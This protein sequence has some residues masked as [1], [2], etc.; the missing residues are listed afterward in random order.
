MKIEAIKKNKSKILIVILLTIFSLNIESYAQVSNQK[1]I[2]EISQEI[3]SLKSQVSK[4]K[5]AS[6]NVK[7]STQDNRKELENI[8]GSM[9]NID[10]K[11]D[12]IS[13]NQAHKDDLTTKMISHLSNIEKDINRLVKIKVEENKLEN[14]NQIVANSADEVNANVE[15]AASPFAFGMGASVVS[16]YVWRGNDFGESPS[17]QPYMS[18]SYAGLELG[19]WSS[20]PF[21]TESSDFNEFDLYLAYSVETGI[22]NFGATLTDYHYPNAGLSFT[23]WEGDG[24]GAHTIEFAMTYSN[25]NL[26]IS[27]MAAYNVHNDPDNSLYLELGYSIDV[28][29]VPV[30]IFVGGAQGTSAWYGIS[31]EKF[32][33]IN[34][35]LTLSKEIKLWDS[36][37]LPV[38]ASYIINPYIGKGF[39][40]FGISI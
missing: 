3:K 31:T 28:N 23:N 12:E 26:P 36:Y 38:Y 6:A 10:G 40:V 32:E 4:I 14:N 39:M 35:G 25:S 2:D 5:L 11:I 1:V 33:L 27:L 24:N 8:Y 34:V 30:N 15:R 7:P 20:Y 37:S 18:V 19:A 21:A 9:N 17:I 29:D 16:R 22:G 13:S